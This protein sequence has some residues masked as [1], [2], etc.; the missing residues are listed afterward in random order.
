M[1][2]LVVICSL[3]LLTACTTTAPVVMK[4]PDAPAEL[5][6]PADKLTPLPKDK[7]ELH[8]ILD[9]VNTNYGKYYE[10]RDKYNAWIEWYNAQK[11]IYEEVK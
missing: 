8:D 1:R 9:N 3:L 10:L 6:K 7:K 11:K 2:S 4:F 5:T